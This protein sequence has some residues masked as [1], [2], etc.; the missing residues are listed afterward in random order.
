MSTLALTDPAV[1]DPD[2]VAD[3]RSLVR[4]YI[5]SQERVIA[6]I[7][8]TTSEIES[9]AELRREVVAMHQRLLKEGETVGRPM[10]GVV[11]GG[12]NPEALRER[13]RRAAWTRW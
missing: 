10:W 3:Y 13:S 2:A 6:S 5:A 9:C 8:T 4:D 11:P 12:S 1:K 7:A